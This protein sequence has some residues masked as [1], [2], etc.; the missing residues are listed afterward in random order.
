MAPPLHAQHFILQQCL[1]QLIVV[2]VDV[3]L[4]ILP[5]KGVCADVPRTKHQRTVR[6]SYASHGVHSCRA[7]GD[8]TVPVLVLATNELMR[9]GAKGYLFAQSSRCC[10]PFRRRRKQEV[11][12]TL[13]GGAVMRLHMRV[14]CAVVRGSADAASTSSSGPEVPK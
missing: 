6:T 9:L 4:R 10:P 5:M 7:L 2:L 1:D 14:K 3:V 12:S 11:V 13:E 8:V